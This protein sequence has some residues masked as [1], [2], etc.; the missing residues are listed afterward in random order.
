MRER[1]LG[2]VTVELRLGIVAA[3][4]AVSSVVAAACASPAPPATDSTST[5]TAAPTDTGEQASAEPTHTPT[6]TPT[7][8]ASIQQDSG[9]NSEPTETPT[10]TPTPEP[11]SDP[12]PS[13]TTVPATTTQQIVAVS[14]PPLGDCFAGALSEDP[15]LCY[16]LEQAQA[17]GLVDIVALYDSG[18]PLYVSIGQA[19]LSEGLLRF[20]VGKSYEFVDS[21]PELVPYEK[22]G[23]YCGEHQ[24]WRD[25][26]KCYLSAMGPGHPDGVLPKPS[27]YGGV[28]LLLGGE[29]ARRSVPGW[30]SWRQLWPRVAAQQGSVPRG[31]PR[32]DVSDVDVTNFPEVDCTYAHGVGC[33]LW[34]EF[35]DLGITGAHGFDNHFYYQIKNPPTDEAE[36]EAIKQKLVPCYDRTGRCVFQH[37]DGGTRIRNNEV[38]TTIEIIAVKYDYRDL[39]RWGT[40]LDR[41]ALSAGNTIGIIDAGVMWNFNS[42]NVIFLNGLRGVDGSQSAD[43]RDTIEVQAHDPQR[44]ADALPALLPLLGIPVDAVGMVRRY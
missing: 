42:Y 11:V 35:P 17:A 43:I 1:R 36:L 32:Y 10:P 33:S 5:P 13:T 19:E 26:P 28:V 23:G 21:W 22:Y 40:V 44:V 18:G 6:S 8:T 9:S 30:G 14:G 27:A 39:W 38:T 4:L 12:E 16:V 41:F 24:D 20:V 25:F 29:S 2:C 3:V 37:S 7:P 15:I 31:A 34:Q